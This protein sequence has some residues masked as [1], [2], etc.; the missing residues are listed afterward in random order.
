MITNWPQITMVILLIIEMWAS[1]E[2]YF[3][4]CNNLSQAFI[5]SLMRIA[6]LVLVLC[7]GGF[8]G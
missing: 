6:I 4:I 8:F 7:K 2:R 3:K 1:I 5:T